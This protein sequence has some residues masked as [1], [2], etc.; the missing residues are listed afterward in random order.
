MLAG[1]VGV[2]DGRDGRLLACFD[3]CD[4]IADE[5]ALAGPRA[6]LPHGLVDQ[7]RTGLEQCRVRAGAGDNQVHA[8]ASRPVIGGAASVGSR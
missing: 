6:E 1:L 3:I 5:R 8:G 2:A 4:G 7:V